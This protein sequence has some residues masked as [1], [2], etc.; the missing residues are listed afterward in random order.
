MLGAAVQQSQAHS[1]VKYII[2]HLQDSL[3][4]AFKLIEVVNKPNVLP[5]DRNAAQTYRAV[6]Q[7]I[8]NSKLSDRASELLSKCHLR[9]Y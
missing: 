6:A 1:E 4:A 7:P 8:P 2:N 3:L 5:T 9:P